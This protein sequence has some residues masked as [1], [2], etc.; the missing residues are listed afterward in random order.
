MEYVNRIRVGAA[1]LTSAISSYGVGTVH[2]FYNLLGSDGTYRLFCSLFDYEIRGKERGC[3]SVKKEIPLDQ[4]PKI[5]FVDTILS[6]LHLA[7]SIGLRGNEDGGEPVR[8]PSI[9]VGI[10]MWEVR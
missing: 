8:S 5:I 3:Y 9:F 2:R 1:H 10:P 7:P 4:E 6:Q